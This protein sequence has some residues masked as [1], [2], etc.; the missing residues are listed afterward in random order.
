MSVTC[1]AAPAATTAAPSI[2]SLLR[3]GS[4]ATVVAAAATVAV[5]AVGQAVG[6]SLAISGA[7]IPVP[8]FATLTV[9][10]SVVGLLI[11]LALR[12]FAHSPRTAWIR[13][14]VALTVLSLVPDLLVDAAIATKVLLMVTH[15]VAAAI[16][17]PAVGRR[18]RG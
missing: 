12:R 8:G 6:I 17:I 2:G 1:T 7:P 9:I 18:L 11:A 14:A 4:V 15:L 16:V 3:G 10:F 13:T 5:A